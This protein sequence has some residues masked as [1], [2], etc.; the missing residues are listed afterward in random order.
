MD[1]ARLAAIALQAGDLP[2]DWRATAS[3]QDAYEAQTQAQMASCLGVRNTFK[4]RTGMAQSPDYTQGDATISSQ[5]SAYRSQGDI[6]ND[7]AMLKRSKIDKCY[8]DVVRREA[9][10]A[11]PDD[12]TV[13]SVSVHT[14][15]QPSG[16]P[17]NVAAT[18]V[19]KMTV[20]TS[21]QTVQLFDDTA[22]ISGPRIEVEVDF[23]SVGQPVPA[24][25]QSQVIA[26]VASRAAAA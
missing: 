26:K 16:R 7:V 6:D 2:S 19:A 13:E 3:A 22:L 24:A 1:K 4:D 17:D 25:L 12:A 11:L 20:S 23:Q 5:V 15:P 14:T 8:A 18:I 21:G 9:A 10:S